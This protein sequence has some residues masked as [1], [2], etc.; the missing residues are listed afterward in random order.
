LHLNWKSKI[1]TLC[2]EES[3]EFIRLGHCVAPSA[4]RIAVENDVQTHLVDR[5]VM[6]F[7]EFLHVFIHPSKKKINDQRREFEI[8]SITYA[9]DASVFF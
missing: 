5:I 1:R 4:S 7:E 2:F 8:I 3:E 9:F 6:I